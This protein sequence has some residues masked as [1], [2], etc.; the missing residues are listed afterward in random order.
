MWYSRTN[1]DCNGVVKGNLEGWMQLRVDTSS[2]THRVD[3]GVFCNE[4]MAMGMEFGTFALNSNQLQ[5]NTYLLR[6]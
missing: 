6:N 5:K 3:I 4:E 2:Y 1:V